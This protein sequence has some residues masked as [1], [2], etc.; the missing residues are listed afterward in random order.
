MPELDFD[1]PLHTFK[2]NNLTY[3]VPSNIEEC[4]LCGSVYSAY[5]RSMTVTTINNAKV[6]AIP[7][8]SGLGGLVHPVFISPLK[9]TTGDV[10]TINVADE[11]LSIYSVK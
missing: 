11:G 1:S 8:N 7:A 6:V 9:L 5:Q 10:I 2:A 3:T 4:Y